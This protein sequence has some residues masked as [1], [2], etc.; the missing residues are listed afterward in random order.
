[1][2]LH[3]RCIF[4][5]GLDLVILWEL[6]ADKLR[7]LLYHCLQPIRKGDKKMVLFEWS[8]Y[9]QSL[10][11]IGSKHKDFMTLINI[12]RK[13]L[14][15]RWFTLFFIQV[16]YKQKSN[17][18]TRFLKCPTFGNKH[19]KATTC[20]IARRISKGVGYCCR[21]NWKELSGSMRLTN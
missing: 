18:S 17:T 13:P 16:D 5:T 21:S 8:H 7:V 9:C 3:S 14:V 1:M 11:M 4:Q 15:F 12:I 2:A 19:V 10:I 6:L 20:P